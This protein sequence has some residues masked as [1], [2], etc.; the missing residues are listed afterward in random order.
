MPGF[1]SYDDLID[2][3]TTNGKKDE[4]QF[5][6]AAVGTNGAAGS[7]AT[8]WD[9]AGNPGAGATPATGAGTTGNATTVGAMGFPDVSADFRHGLV[10]GAVASAACT[11]MIYDRLVA[12]QIPASVVSAAT[13]TKTINQTAAPRYTG[14]RAYYSQVWI[15]FPV[16]A[17]TTNTLNVAL[18]SYT[19]G[20]GSTAASGA[21]TGITT[22]LGVRRSMWQLPLSAGKVGVRSIEALSISGTAPASP[23]EFNVMVMRPIAR[24]PLLANQWNEKDLVLQ[25]A[26]L[27]RIYDG[28]SLAFALMNTGANQPVLNGT[29]D[30]GYG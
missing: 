29:F 10:L 16:A 26:S 25:L 17:V 6:K 5:M 9:A 30:T 24:I 19:T 13:G 23:T 11:L 27:P 28:A 18:Q 12:S 14:T 8:L 20:D 2:E 15:E 7:W 3:I 4:Y 21:Y 22:A 1:Q